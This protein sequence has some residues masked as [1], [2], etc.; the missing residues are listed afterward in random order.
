MR[1]C[2][3]GERDLRVERETREIDGKMKNERVR[4]L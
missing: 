3:L 2:T 1:K 4:E